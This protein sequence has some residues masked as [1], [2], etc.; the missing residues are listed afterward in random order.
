MTRQ[1]ILRVLGQHTVATPGF[2]FG[3]IVVGGFFNGDSGGY[4]RPVL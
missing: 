4:K 2:Y 1:D 3:F